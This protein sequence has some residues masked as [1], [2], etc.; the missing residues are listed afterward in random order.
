MSIHFNVNINST[1]LVF[2]N[3]N[4]SCRTSVRQYQYTS[5][6]HCLNYTFAN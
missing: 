3:A 2:P 6:T 1:E 5:G 4:L